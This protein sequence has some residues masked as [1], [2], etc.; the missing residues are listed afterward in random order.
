MGRVD[1]F[2]TII[3]ESITLRGLVGTPLKK[4]VRI[5][6]KKN[7]PF[8]IIGHSLHHG[9]SIRYELEQVEGSAGKE[10]ILTVENQKNE[11]GNYVDVISLTTDSRIRP[12]I[13]I[14]VK[15]YIRERPSKQ[16]KSSS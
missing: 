13:N 14:Y 9:N 11:P 8:K 5:I 6:P 3:P 2:V 12:T 10:Y 7:Y 16:S 1:K 4:S 15:G